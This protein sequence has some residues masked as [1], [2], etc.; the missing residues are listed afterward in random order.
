MTLDVNRFVEIR[1]EIQRLVVTETH[2]T[3]KTGQISSDR[4]SLVSSTKR[5]IP[6][7]TGLRF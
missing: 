4:V 5:N 7:Y 1:L 2:G 6:D 3:E